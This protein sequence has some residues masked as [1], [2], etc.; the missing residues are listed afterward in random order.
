[1]LG[2]GYWWELWKCR[3][4]EKCDGRDGEDWRQ[5]RWEMWDMMMLHGGW[6]VG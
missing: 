5:Y 2:N 1:M 6:T 4:V 3:N